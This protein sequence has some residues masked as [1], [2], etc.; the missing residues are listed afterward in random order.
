MKKDSLDRFFK[1]I[2]LLLMVVI[3]ADCNKR[4][5][6]NNS[7]PE[8]E[9]I[10][11][12]EPKEMVITGEVSSISAFSATMSGTVNL[13]S[14]MKDFK[15]GILVS[16]KEDAR[17]NEGIDLESKELS[18]QNSF[19]VTTDRL[20]PDTQY[21]FKAYL[22]TGGL[23]RY[24]EIKSFKTSA[25]ELSVITQK[26]TDVTSRNVTLNGKVTVDNE[27]SS[28]TEVGFRYA[29]SQ[30]D[31]TSGKDKYTKGEKGENGI[32]SKSLEG[33]TPETTYF[34]RACATYNNLEVFGEIR[35]FTTDKEEV[36]APQELI[37]TLEATSVTAVTATLVGEAHPTSELGSVLLGF[38]VSDNA[39]PDRSNSTDYPVMEMG[40]QNQF[41]ANINNL[42]PKTR[43]YY[44]AY[45]Q[46][47]GL[48][49]YGETLSFET[50]EALKL[51]T[52]AASDITHESAKLN[53]SVTILY[54]YPSAPLVTGFIYSRYPE[55]V[56]DEVLDLDEPP[57]DFHAIVCDRNADGSFSGKAE[58]LSPNSLYYYRPYA[59]YLD[60]SYGEFGEIKTFKTLEM[61]GLQEVSDWSITYGG[62]KNLTNSDGSVSVGEAFSFK[63]TGS[64]YFFVRTVT[65]KE[66]NETYNGDIKSLF[67]KEASNLADRAKNEGT[68]ITQLTGVF[69][70]GT[71]STYFDL[72]FHNNYIAFMIEITKEGT[73]TGNYAKTPCNVV[74]ET[75]SGGFLRWLGR[76]KISDGSSSFY[77]DISSCE[78]NYLYYVNGWET[79]AGIS[80]QM[81]GSEDWFFA[82][83]QK[84]DGMLYFYGQDI[85]SYYDSDF[86]SNADKVFAGEYIYNGNT[87]LD[88]EGVDNLYDIA[89]SK[90]KDGVVTLIPESFSL[91]D[92]ATVSYSLMRYFEYVYNT[93]KW[94]HYNSSGIPIFTNKTVTM[95]PV[96]SSSQLSSFK[97]PAMHNRTRTRSLHVLQDKG[98]VRKGKA[99]Y[100]YKNPNSHSGMRLP[101]PTSVS[102]TAR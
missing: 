96:S 52:G 62:R 86:K 94:Y 85:E 91:E 22:H 98:S 11:P 78:A 72:L 2:A 43:Y 40:K 33:L 61:T 19:S 30:E 92:G 68:S 101:C 49:H 46:Y 67:E 37:I 53:G 87:Y 56:A 25:F 34:Y 79:G 41:K 21:Y 54:D 55:S 83:Y 44:K 42:I 3:L 15:F 10:D 66:I 82:R 81:N 13:T 102:S 63:Y 93:Q 35:S 36:P 39:E 38:L 28:A 29:N 12:V 16:E 47:G 45:I 60:D 80:Y 32:F 27:F 57:T 1:V 88:V 17:I 76:W 71:T 100:Q 9:P 90:V 51:T 84:E 26:E 99:L 73:V 50:S 64:N 74:E 65:T 18:S 58:D 20:K 4:E 70:K 31:L 77:V 97:A 7:E 8:P 89:H 59:F 23:Y 14:D 95:S 75:P 6:Y 24:G 69:D 48:Y 5:P